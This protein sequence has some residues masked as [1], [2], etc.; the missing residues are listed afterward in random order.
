VLT[1][2][3]AGGIAGTIALRGAVRLFAETGDLAAALELPR[4]QKNPYPLYERIRARGPVYRGPSRA[5]VITSHALC[6]D[7]ARDQRLKVQTIHGRVPGGATNALADTFISFDAPDHTRLRRIAAP[8]FRPKLMRELR[9]KVEATTHRLL[10]QL[11]PEFDMMT[12]FAAP[13]PIAVISDLLGIPA[14]DTS[15]FARYGRIVAKAFD[16][17]TRPGAVLDYRAAVED[18]RDLFTRL[19][20]ERRADP[21]DDVISMLVAAETDA[22][23]TADE[24]IATCRLLLIAGFETTVNMIGNAT[25]LFTTH[26]DQWELLRANP[27]LAPGAVE[28]VLRYESPV[29]MLGRYAHEPMRLADRDLPV[30]AAVIALL[31][32]ANRD[33]EV[34]CD[35]HTFD[36][37]REGSVE[38]LAFGGGAHY[39]LGAPLTRLEGDVAFR[40]LVDRLPK[41]RLT[42][43][44]VRRGSAQ[45]RGFTTIPVAG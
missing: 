29:P 33:P 22:R 13:L 4:Y 34:F 14:A 35:P 41:L 21:G 3:E 38:H 12:G 28:E 36:I 15:R 7:V 18:L 25:V 9:R 26:P 23:L 31:G 30:N 8:A 24:L 20:T 37:T 10:D 2:R 5:Y 17:M 19:M 43:T 6:S 16:G 39:C 45:I 1:L 32:A 40:A 11:T 44:P 42:G 27:D